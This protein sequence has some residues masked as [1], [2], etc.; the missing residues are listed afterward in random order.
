MLL[1]AV[2]RLF[3]VV[4]LPLLGTTE[5]RYASIA[6]D[7]ART[8]HWMVPRICVYGEW[9]SYWGK[10]PLAF[11]LPAWM[12]KVFGQSEFAVRLP[13]FLA[14]VAML[15]LLWLLARRLFGI[16]T[17]WLAVLVTA[18]SVFFFAMWGLVTVDLF[19]SLCVTGVIASH[20]LRMPAAPNPNRRSAR[21]LGRT[22]NRSG[23]GDAIRTIWGYLFFAFLATGFLSKGPIVAILGLGPVAFHLA[24]TRTWREARS[25]PWFRGGIPALAVVLLWIVA[26]ES[27][28]PGFLHH[29]FVREHFSRYFDVDFADPYGAAHSQ[30]PG[31][32]VAWWFALPL[33]WLFPLAAGGNRTIAAF[34]I[35]DCARREDLVLL[36]AWSLWPLVFFAACRSA[37]PSYLLPGLGGTALLIAA[38]LKELL[39]SEA[40]ARRAAVAT[41][42][43]FAVVILLV[44]AATALRAQLG[45]ALVAAG[46]LAVVV[47]PALD[48]RQPALAPLRVGTAGLLCALF[49]AWPAL[50]ES[51]S[52][53]TRSST[54]AAVAE[55]L[56][57]R[58]DSRRPVLILRRWEHAMAVYGGD[59]VRFLPKLGGDEVLRA[60][61]DRKQD[62][63]ILRSDY[64]EELPP[65]VAAHLRPHDHVGIFTIYTDDGAPDG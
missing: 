17:A 52:I 35:L 49:A 23:S 34:R 62:T 20:A 41:S 44:L 4:A 61:S 30:I 33:P 48:R 55:A 27:A 3:G 10:P 57:S 1:L 2:A 58:S 46:G 16:A 51:R 54:R 13:S 63:Y 38:L 18:S 47:F 65:A 21:A 15:S 43:P 64:E 42:L 26:A 25:L 11:W 37:L 59:R 28:S 53:Q 32:G 14:G 24:W 60:T 31:I 40:S 22:V 29:F 12:V 50:H 39:R 6:A 56:A 19:A 36:L 45:A 7:T 9:E 5:G 8:G